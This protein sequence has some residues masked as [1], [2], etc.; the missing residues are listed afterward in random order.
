VVDTHICD[1]YNILMGYRKHDDSST[2]PVISNTKGALTLGLVFII[3]G[4]IGA[5][6]KLSGAGGLFFI[7]AG[8]VEQN[9][10]NHLKSNCQPRQDC[11]RGV[12]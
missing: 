9:H 2:E 6:L 4:I 12:I 8:I 10:L 3:V 11:T 7:L 5:V 1:T